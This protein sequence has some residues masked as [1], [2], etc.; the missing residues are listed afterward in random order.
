MI[1][2]Y[3]GGL[4][5]VGA[6]A[7]GVYQN[8]AVDIPPAPAT[9][10]HST[11][12]ALGGQAANVPPQAQNRDS[13]GH[14]TEEVQVEVLFHQDIFQ[15]WDDRH[16][17]MATRSNSTMSKAQAQPLDGESPAAD[18]HGLDL[19]GQQSSALDRNND[20]NMDDSDASEDAEDAFKSELK[21]ENANAKVL[22]SAYRGGEDFL[23]DVC[24]ETD[25]ELIRCSPNLTDPEHTKLLLDI[26][27]RRKHLEGQAKLLDK[28]AQKNRELIRL[29]RLGDQRPENN[30]KELRDEILKDEQKMWATHGEFCQ[31]RVQ[32]A[33]E[34]SLKFKHV[35][36]NSAQ[37]IRDLKK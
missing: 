32:Q 15:M 30:I 26:F 16:E 37:T 14:Q 12:Q 28:I 23:Q 29:E 25:R 2:G 8:N 1:G 5:D 33:K 22:P 6:P 9:A 13:Q 36:H 11:E 31:C 17:E 18:A 19:H 20:T 7:A 27:T 3:G 34:F 4:N 10:G 24:N 35:Y 21:P